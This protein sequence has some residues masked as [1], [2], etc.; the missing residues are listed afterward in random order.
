M[1]RGVPPHNDTYYFSLHE[2]HEVRLKCTPLHARIHVH[3]HAT[4]HAHA[5]PNT[6]TKTH[7]HTHTL[8][9]S[10]TP[11]PS[12]LPLGRTQAGLSKAKIKAALLDYHTLLVKDE[13]ADLADI[14]EDDD[15]DDDD[16][17]EEEGGE[18]G[19]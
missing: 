11:P 13:F 5:H 4:A 12:P 1:A 9:L 15:D 2:L 16:D 17:G 3:V 14:P 18:C 6:H 8:S 10:L 19:T 7:T